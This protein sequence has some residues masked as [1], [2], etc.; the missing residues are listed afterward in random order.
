M[1]ASTDRTDRVCL[2]ETDTWEAYI[3][4]L[5]SLPDH[6]DGQGRDG[7]FG[8]YVG[9]L[10]DFQEHFLKRIAEDPVF[11][12]QV[13]SLRGLSLGCFCRR[14]EACHGDVILAYL[15]GTPMPHKVSEDLFSVSGEPDEWVEL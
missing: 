7:E 9:G 15:N 10:V 14:T 12:S 11:K 1:P 4:R 13:E 8:N 3:G 5:V 2:K 6:F